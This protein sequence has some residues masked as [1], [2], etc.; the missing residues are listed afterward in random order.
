MHLS[1]ERNFSYFTADD[2]RERHRRIFSRIG[3]ESSVFIRGGGPVG[4]FEVFRQTNEFYYLTGIAVPQ[5]YLL[6]DG[7]RQRSALYLPHRDPHTVSEGAAL[8]AD[9]EGAV[10]EISGVDAVYGLEQLSEHLAHSPA[11]FYLPH[12][13]AEGRL[14]CQDTLRHAAKAVA[15][16]P[17]DA[18]PSREEK[19]IRKLCEKRP[20]AIIHDLSPLLDEMRLIKSPGEIAVMRRA[21]ALSARSVTEAIRS[22]RPDLY[23]YQL[24]AI[25]EYVYWMNGASGEGYRPIIASGKNIWYSHYYRNDSLL[26]SG[27]LVLMDYAPDIHNY[28]SDI[29]RMWPINGRYSPV[30][31]QLYGFMVKYHRAVLKNI[32][33]EVT[34]RQVLAEAADTM[35]P[36]AEATE[37]AKPIYREA[38]LRALDFTGHLSHPVGMA[39]H[40]VGRYF[41]RPL[42]PGLVFSVDP[43][44][45]VPEEKLYVRVEDTVVVTEDGVEVLTAD[46]PTDLDAI[47]ALMA[48]PGLIEHFPMSV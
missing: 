4:G 17:W 24:G 5:A 25:A 21:S 30:Q 48:E 47:E 8:S 36:V 44:L 46:C 35:R 41:D 9:D 20:N 39:V 3:S 27:D 34:P 6:I 28:T 7:A 22:T 11:N 32:R 15:A 13:P 29:G 2:F 1:T 43:Q 23:E 38:A 40:D 16:D 10:K 45:W 19:L 26:Q 12:S 18:E 37:F 33:P 14:A 31:R 42:M